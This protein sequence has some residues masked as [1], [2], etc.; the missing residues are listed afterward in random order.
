LKVV[1]TL[2]V[3]FCDLEF[4]LPCILIVIVE[5]T[6]YEGELLVRLK[7]CQP[8]GTLGD[9]CRNVSVFPMLSLRRQDHSGLAVGASYVKWMLNQN[10]FT[11]SR[12]KVA[13][14]YDYVLLPYLAC[15][16]VS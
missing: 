9:L 14:F 11:V 12:S 1:C 16:R 13:V 10:R 4:P 2:Q 3:A 7:G 5:G 8:H 15:C 6:C